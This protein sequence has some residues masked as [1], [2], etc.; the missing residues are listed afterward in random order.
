MG[1]QKLASP[2]GTASVTEGMAGGQGSLL[3]VGVS[4]CAQSFARNGEV[5]GFGCTRFWVC[6]CKA[7][8]GLDSGVSVYVVSIVKV[9]PPVLY[10]GG[11]PRAL[12]A[13]RCVQ[14][15]NCR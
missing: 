7:A 8:V 4:C 11:W 6:E 9:C 14:E 10:S 1:A 3:T 15:V 5:N 12:A 2:E 13:G